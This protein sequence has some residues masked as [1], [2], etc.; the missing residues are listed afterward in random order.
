MASKI[1]VTMFLK[2]D[3]NGSAKVLA[4]K[5]EQTNSSA[6]DTMKMALAYAHFRQYKNTMILLACP[7]KILHKNCFYFPLGLRIIEIRMFI[8]ALN[9]NRT[10]IIIE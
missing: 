2:A 7:S 9:N 8:R 3:F 1:L 4:K 10:D 5:I 6:T